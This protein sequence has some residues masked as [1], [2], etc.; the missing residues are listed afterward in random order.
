MNKLPTVTY[1]PFL[2][3]P[4]LTSEPHLEPSAHHSHPPVH[5]FLCISQVLCCFWICTCF[6][7]A[8]NVPI[9]LHKLALSSFRT[10]TKTHLSLIY[11]F[12]AINTCNYLQNSHLQCSHQAILN[13]F[14]LTYLFTLHMPYQKVNLIRVRILS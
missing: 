1:T 2:F 11:S 4:L 10:P 13:L 9:S 7:P 6:L 12:V 5:L 8:R 3:P 14:T